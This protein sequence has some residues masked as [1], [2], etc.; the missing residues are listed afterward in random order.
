M[1][2]T[3]QPQDI[4]AGKFVIRQS[5]SNVKKDTTFARTVASKIGFNMG[6]HTKTKPYGLIDVFTDGAYIPI[7]TKEKMAKMFN[8]DEFG[9]RPLTKEEAIIMLKDIRQDLLL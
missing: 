6:D 1:K 8:D 4:E 2:Y 7:G 5:S 3:W 9:Y